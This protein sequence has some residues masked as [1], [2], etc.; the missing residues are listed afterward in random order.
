MPTNN[1]LKNIKFG[2]AGLG[3]NTKPTNSYLN[4]GNE[5]NISVFDRSY[6]AGGGGPSYLRENNNNL[7]PLPYSSKI[8]GGADSK[9]AYRTKKTLNNIT[10][11]GGTNNLNTSNLDKSFD[12]SFNVGAGDRSFNLNLNQ[13][14]NQ[15]NNNNSPSPDSERTKPYNSNNNN[16]NA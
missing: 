11:G 8:N 7:T 16:N 2:N 12:N 6:N 1:E 10:S 13:V 5:N 15:N 4:S 3:V 9:M 14:Y